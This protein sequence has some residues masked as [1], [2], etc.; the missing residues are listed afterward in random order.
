MIPRLVLLGWSM[1][2]AWGAV[3]AG[4]AAMDYFRVWA[5]GAD[6]ARWTEIEAVD[7]RELEAHAELMGSL[8]GRH[9]S[10]PRLHLQAA[11]AHEWRAYVARYDVRHAADQLH[12]A[13]AHL[14]HAV[15]ARPLWSEAWAA[16][17]ELDTRPGKEWNDGFALRLDMALSL[18][19]F[20][21]KTQLYL[22]PFVFRNW[23][24]LPEQTQIRA[25]QFIKDTH[26]RRGPSRHAIDRLIDAFPDH[27]LE[28]LLREDSII[29]ARSERS[30]VAA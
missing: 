7:D 12:K 15:R 22:I 8:A 6:I 5:I 18:G 2:A 26:V 29:G 28:R 17:L 20:D 30:D 4:A 11:R 23:E 9:P 10:D 21:L 1:A 14:E 16:W 27:P 13:V 3:A 25:Y 24:R 19:S